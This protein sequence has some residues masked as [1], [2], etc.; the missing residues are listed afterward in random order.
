MGDLP[1]L[2]TFFVA[3]SAFLK[4]TMFAGTKLESLCFCVLSLLHGL[5]L[6]NVTFKQTV[7]SFAKKGSVRIGFI[8]RRKE[9]SGTEEYVEI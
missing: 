9:M 4:A 1:P 8:E 7:L 3:S 5:L 6:K 2:R